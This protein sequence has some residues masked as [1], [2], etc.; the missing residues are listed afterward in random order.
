MLEDFAHNLQI[1]HIRILLY[2]LY[3]QWHNQMN[4]KIRFGILQCDHNAHYYFIF[5]YVLNI[6]KNESC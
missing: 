3:F 5:T 4:Q 2:P 1:L 6:H